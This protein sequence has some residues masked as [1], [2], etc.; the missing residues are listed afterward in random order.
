[1]PHPPRPHRWDLLRPDRLGTLLDGADAP[2]LWYLEELTDCAAKV[3]ARGGDAE[4][5]FVGRSADSVF[6]L[7]GG[8]LTGTAWA[9][10]LA[11]L[12]LSCPRLDF[13]QRELALLRDHLGAA[14]F[15]PRDLA[16]RER[17]LVLVDLV[18]A[19]RTFTTLHTVL[20][21]WIAESREPWPVIRRKLRYLGITSRTR[22]SPKTWRWQQ[23]QAWTAELPARG[24]RNVSL[25]PRVWSLLGDYQPK[26]APSFP[27]SRWRDETVT[28]PARGEAPTRALA[29]AVALVAAGRTPAVR[30][31][32]VRTLAAEPAFGGPWLRTLAGEIGG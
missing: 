11:R 26:T 7:L 32:V 30:R 18:W 29:T 12:P 27:P 31:R 3:L 8:V 22:T 24:V 23:H 14:G 6:D 13:S 16:R 25:D 10:R 19:G 15:A 1:M 9:S 21:D 20:R 5:R 2:N 4:L 28:A 17:P